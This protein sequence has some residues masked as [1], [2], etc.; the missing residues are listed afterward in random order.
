M[1]PFILWHEKNDKII[2]VLDYEPIK[3]TCI[4]FNKSSVILSFDIGE[5][6]IIHFY[7]ELELFSDIKHTH[8]YFIEK[9]NKI[10]ITLVKL[11]NNT[12]TSLTKHKDNKVKIDWTKWNYI[13][14]MQDNLFKIPDLYTKNNTD[15]LINSIELSDSD[16]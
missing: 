8:S 13:D 4:T 11:I 12:W 2:L 10:I 1:E 15:N 5:S 9:S 6:N 16:N 3:N 14:D 7:K